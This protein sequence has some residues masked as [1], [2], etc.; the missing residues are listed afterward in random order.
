MKK[1]AGVQIEYSQLKNNNGAI[2]IF[3]VV[4]FFNDCNISVKNDS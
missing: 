1:G 3:L 2:A 4:L